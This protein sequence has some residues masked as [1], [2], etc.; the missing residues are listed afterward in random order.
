M[1]YRPGPKYEITVFTSPEQA[2]L[3]MIEPY[4]GNPNFFSTGPE[5]KTLKLRGR[6]LFGLIIMCHVQNH[7]MGEKWVPGTDPMGH[8]GVVC[9]ASGDRQGEGSMY[10]QVFVPEVRPGDKPTTLENRILEAIKSKA[11]RGES[12]RSGTDLIVFVNRAGTIGNLRG[13]AGTAQKLEY[14]TIYLIA[15]YVLKNSAE[16]LS[17]LC[18]IL[19]SPRETPG[20]LE[21]KID[22][23]TGAGQV[24]RIMPDET[25]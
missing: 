23:N 8:D 21:V 16:E 2:Y 5:H 20:P 11:N 1:T 3:D 4:I 10:E 7:L 22:R 15:Q 6:E 13:L 9:R 12:Y 18:I 14:E 24:H 25:K 19:S 17:F